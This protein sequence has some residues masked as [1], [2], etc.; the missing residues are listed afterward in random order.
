[1]L[2]FYENERNVMDWRHCWEPIS[3]SIWTNSRVDMVGFV[4]PHKVVARS[5][6]ST[7]WNAW[8]GVELED[9]V[10]SERLKCEFSQVEEVLDLQKIPKLIPIPNKKN[11]TKKKL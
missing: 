6:V 11:T 2:K 1:L 9:G 7:F 10:K 5:V 4:Y 8:N 3:S